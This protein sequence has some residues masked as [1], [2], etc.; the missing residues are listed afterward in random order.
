MAT[1]SFERSL[2]IRTEAEAETKTII[3]YEIPFTRY[4]YKYV[5][6]RSSAEIIKEII[7][8]D[9]GIAKLMKEIV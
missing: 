1:T 4:F 9:G 7:E 5:K 6:P 3:G 8:L 2:E